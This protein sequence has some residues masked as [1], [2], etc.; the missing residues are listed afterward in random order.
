MATSPPLE[1]KVNLYLIVTLPFSPGSF[2]HFFIYS[3]SIFA[4]S[5]MRE[6]LK[7]NLISSFFLV[8]FSKKRA[9]TKHV[10]VPAAR[11]RCGGGSKLRYLRSRGDGFRIRRCVC[12]FH[13]GF[14]CSHE[15]SIPRRVWRVSFASHSNLYSSLPSFSLPHHNPDRIPRG[16]LQHVSF[17]LQLQFLTLLKYHNRWILT[18]PINK[19]WG[20]KI[21]NGGQR[22]DERRERLSFGA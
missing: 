15:I 19:P 20:Y 7:L 1:E 12:P 14:K 3:A 5:E 16:A 8:T 21:T 22:W 10:P 2:H 13:N 11:R 4:D 9:R 18:A 6:S 17:A